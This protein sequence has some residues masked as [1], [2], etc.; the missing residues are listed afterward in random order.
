[1]IPIVYNARSMLQ[2]PVST[3]FTAVGIALVVAV[4]IAM[5]ALGQGLR[6]ALARTGSDRNVVVVRKGADSELT[7]GLSRETARILAASPHVATGAD[8]RPMVSPEVYV[9][10]PL[11]RPRDTASVANVVVRGVSEQAWAVRNNLQVIAGNKPQ[12]G[13]AEVCVGRKLLGRFEHLEIGATLRFA[14]RD[15]N[16][17]CHFSAGGSA[18]ESEIWAENEQVMPVFRGDFFQSVT[19]RLKDPA[20]FAEAKRAI[21]SDPQ[22]VVDVHRESTFYAAQTGVAGQLLRVLA[23]A[24]T[25]IMSIGAIFGAV[26]TMYAAV[27]SRTPEIAVLLTLGFRPWQVLFSFLAEAVLIAGLGAILGALLALPVNGVVTST[28]NWTS[29]S[30][31]AFSFRITPLLLGIGIAFGVVMGFI[32]GFFP[33]WRAAR[34]RVVQALR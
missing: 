25:A 33:A 14:G 34:L 9:L 8:G 17:V 10:I 6:A 5:L 2:R 32:G 22:T 4:F 24:V 12:S 26:N 16:V 31:I 3:T 13:R 18:F 19:F 28:T 7:S 29:F 15:W 21:E 1:M 11:P 23:I 27:G 30:E 20:A